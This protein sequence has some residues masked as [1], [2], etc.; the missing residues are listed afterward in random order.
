MSQVV[1]SV[2]GNTERRW[3]R[4]RRRAIRLWR[5]ERTVLLHPV[6]GMP[7]WT[8]PT[9]AALIYLTLRYGLTLLIL[10]NPFHQIVDNG[11]AVASLAVALVILLRGTPGGLLRWARRRNGG[12]ERSQSGQALLEMA[13]LTPI[14]LLLCL[15]CADFGRVFY[16]VIALSNG[17]R[18]AARTAS[19]SSGND[20]VLRA[21]FCEQ[22]YFSWNFT[23]PSGD[24]CPAAAWSTWSPWYTPEPALPAPNTAYIAISEDEAFPAD[25]PTGSSNWSTAAR[26]GGHRPVQVQ[27]DY[28]WQPLTP[29]ISNLLPNGVVH[30]RLASQEKEQY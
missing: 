16:T 10:R 11:A 9:L 24:P 21:A 17:A 25:V 7:W 20:Q 19:V 30:I 5:G 2:G 4:L 28:Y 22:P 12:G 3:A 29:F 23:P 8:Y 6:F 1:V 27:I 13:L 18:E 15:G 26:Q 14:L